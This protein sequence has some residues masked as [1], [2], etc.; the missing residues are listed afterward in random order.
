MTFNL[1]ISAGEASSDLHAANALRELHA[2][3]ITPSCFGMGGLEL[4]SLGMTLDVD[5]RELAV[6]GIVE[7]LARY[8]EFRRKL[9][10]SGAWSHTWRCSFRS[11]RVTTKPKGF[12]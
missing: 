12:R 2:R 7:V 11:R 1:M 10:A 6:I 8:P 9:A 4:Q 3:G 5:N